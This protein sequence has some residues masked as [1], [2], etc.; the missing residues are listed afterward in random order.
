MDTPCCGPKGYGQIIMS[1]IGCSGSTA[2]YVKSNGQADAVHATPLHGR[3]A[4]ICMPSV[5]LELPGFDTFI[6]SCALSF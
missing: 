3:V 2:T 1:T 4:V 6:G 5:V